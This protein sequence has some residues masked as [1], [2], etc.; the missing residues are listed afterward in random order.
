MTPNELRA[1]YLKFFADKGHVIIP[2]ASLIPENDS[3]TLFTGSGMQPMLP[4]LLGEKYPLG[5]RIVDSQKCFRAQ[6]IEEVGDSRHTTFFE[7]L[8]NWSLGDY[9]KQEQ[10]E[11]MFEF[12]TNVVGLDPK[13]LYVTVFRGNDELKIFRD[14]DAAGV[15]KREFAKV[16][17]EAKDVDFSDRDGLQGGRIFYYGEKKNWWSRVGAPGNMPVGE[18]GG[19]DSEMFWDF[20]AERK[21]HENSKFKDRPCHV[22]CDCGRFIEIGN[23]VFMQYLKTENGFEKL[24]SGNIDFGGGLERVLAAKNNEPDI[25]KTELFLPIINK[26]EELSG[27]KYEDY[28][29]EFQVIADHI[30]AATFLLFEGVVPSNVDRGYV[31]RRL[32]RRVITK[33]ENTLGGLAGDYLNLLSDEVKKTFI[34]VYDQL[35]ETEVQKKIAKGFSDEE[36]KFKKTLKGGLR[37]F[38]KMFAKKKFISGED[39]F[40]LYSTY[41]FPL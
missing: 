15:W 4:Y 6:D 11:W 5:N 12:L 2:S 38:E 21:V 7:M 29:K 32:I 14:V 35:F 28:K 8:G 33:A 17:V 25:F 18:P 24:P 13:R 34:G 10:I 20:G 30:R 41:G 40:I 1:A 37:E 19:P 9:F 22:N 31:L 39:A 26:I 3:T 27:K 36:I 16:G 23:N